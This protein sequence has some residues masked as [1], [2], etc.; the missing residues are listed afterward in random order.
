M[1][2]QASVWK[3]TKSGV[4]VLWE[5][6]KVIIPAVVVVNILEK[7]GWLTHISTTLGPLMA[8]FGLPG[9]AALVLVTANF[10]SFYAG[11]GTMVALALTWKQLTVLSAMVMICHAA[12]SETALVAKAGANAAWV[13]GARVVAAIM[14][15]LALNW[16]LPA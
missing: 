1:D 5:L 13:L 4:K 6:A 8:A 15:G 2:V 12:I 16:L 10:V 7:T 3:G 11:L 9:E 14:V